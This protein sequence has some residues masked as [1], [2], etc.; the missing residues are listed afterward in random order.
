MKKCKHTT[1]QN[2]S[3]YKENGCDEILFTCAFWEDDTLPDDVL[4]FMKY[5][6]YK[7]ESY[8]TKRMEKI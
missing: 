7:L 5:V 1:C 2:Y 4:E 6:E 3:S 8:I